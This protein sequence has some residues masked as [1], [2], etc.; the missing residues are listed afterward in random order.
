MGVYRRYVVFVFFLIF[1]NV[2]S[3]Y[4]TT[5][6][7][8][9]NFNDGVIDTSFWNY[10]YSSDG[11]VVEQ[12]GILKMQTSL[13]AASA[14][15]YTNDDYDIYNLSVS[16]LFTDIVNGSV[17]FYVY[18]EDATVSASNDTVISQTAKIVFESSASLGQFRL[19]YVD[20]DGVRHYWNQA[21]GVWQTSSSGVA[22]LGNH[23]YTL[24]VNRTNLNYHFKLLDGASVVMESD[25]LSII[26]VHDYGYG[27]R[28]IFGDMSVTSGRQTVKIDNL[29]LNWIVFDGGRLDTVY[30]RAIMFER[31]NDIAPNRS[32]QQQIGVITNI[33]PDLVFR[34][35]FAWNTMPVN[36]SDFPGIT[37]VCESRKYS[38]SYFNETMSA[39]KSVNGSIAFMTGF[40]PQR[41]SRDSFIDVDK[42]VMYNYPDTYAMSADL[43]KFG[44]YY[45]SKGVLID[46]D[47][48]Q[49]KLGKYSGWISKDFECYTKI[50][51]TVYNNYDP[52]GYNSYFPDITNQDY[53]NALFAQIKEM[54]DIGSEVIFLDMNWKEA[55]AYVKGSDVDD[56]SV[57]MVLRYE[58]NLG[59]DIHAYAASQGKEVAVGT[60]IGNY[61][62]KWPDYERVPALDFVAGRMKASEIL[63]G[64][65]DARWDNFISWRD[66]FF[67]DIPMYLFIDWGG[68]KDYPMIAFAQKKTSQGQKDFINTSRDFV[69]QYDNVIFVYPVHG[70]QIGNEAGYRKKSYGLYN[71]YDSQAPE[72]DTYGLICSILQGPSCGTV[73]QLGDFDPS[74]YVL[75]QDYEP[76]W[77]AQVWLHNET[78]SNTV[79]A[80]SEG[81]WEGE[82]TA[83][84]SYDY[85]VVKSGYQSITGSINFSVP[86]SGKPPVLFQLFTTF[87]PSGYVNDSAGNPLENAKVS[88]SNGTYSTYDFTDSSGYWNVNIYADGEYDYNVSREGYNKI[89]GSNYF[90][91]GGINYNWTLS[92][93]GGSLNGTVYEWT[94]GTAPSHISFD[95]E[96]YNKVSN[97]VNDS[98]G[99]YDVAQGG[100]LTWFEGYIWKI[101]DVDADERYVHV[102]LL[103]DGYEFG[104]GIYREGDTV[105]FSVYQDFDQVVYLTLTIKKVF[106]G[107]EVRFV[108]V[109]PGQKLHVKST[110]EKIITG[111]AAGVSQILDYMFGA[112]DTNRRLLAYM[113]PDLQADLVAHPVTGTNPC[114]GEYTSF[115]TEDTYYKAV[116]AFNESGTY[117]IVDASFKA[118]V[119]G[120]IRS[121]EYG[122]TD[123]DVDMFTES[124]YQKISG[125]S[126]CNIYPTASRNFSDLDGNGNKKIKIWVRIKGGDKP[127]LLYNQYASAACVNCNLK[128]LP[129]A[130]VYYNATRGYSAV[131]DNL[132]NYN[133]EMPFGS[134]LLVKYYKDGYQSKNN[135]FNFALGNRS[136]TYNVVLNKSDTNQTLLAHEIW[137]LPNVITQGQ[138]GTVYYRTLSSYWEYEV[139]IEKFGSDKALDT[140]SIYPVKEDSIS[141]NPYPAGYY[142]ASLYGSNLGFFWDRIVWANFTVRSD[143][144]AVNWQS[145]E[146][147]MNDVMKLD[148]DIPIGVSNQNVSVYYPNSSIMYTGDHSV[149]GEIQTLSWDTS[150]LTLPSGSY[151]A[152]ITNNDSQSITMLYPMNNTNFSLTAPSSVSWGETISIK[153]LSPKQSEFHIYGSDGFDAIRSFIVHGTG[154]YS[155]N[156]SVLPNKD[157]NIKIN[158]IRDRVIVAQANVS[159]RKSVVSGSGGGSAVGD[160]FL[161]FMGYPAFWGLIFWLIGVV[162]VSQ[163]GRP[164]EDRSKL[165]EIVAVVGAAFEAVIGLWEPY[166]WWVI[167]IIVIVLGSKFYASRKAQEGG[168]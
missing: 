31:L 160:N 11:S 6:S 163:G 61:P 142:V 143:K 21:L 99:L 32:I 41:M 129:G 70:G 133:I 158:L 25:D 36:C 78:W 62:G 81:Y 91:V 69:N 42:G 149:T 104:S 168:G 145:N 14:F 128:R 141:M 152:K 8:S 60:W 161:T 108:E 76:L 68:G 90:T 121:I 165:T 3:A 116:L 87:D 89:T 122:F 144:A 117:G 114:G 30:R 134:N 58:N 103:R 155:F 159:V 39:I 120:G 5:Y 35:S 157:Q 92:P 127:L 23:A 48:T 49:C 26:E 52:T 19:S 34:A 101:Q 50:N 156:T 95:L 112:A 132:G 93:K 45:D 154:S 9:D 115:G 153:Y 110:F 136:Q 148:I 17:G 72:F 102:I 51:D 54:I 77:G 125:I 83:A 119:S 98:E 16:I 146:Y 130:T 80:D 126:S 73:Q 53:Y 113:G 140:Y 24:L 107:R 15:A 1:L 64:Y 44:E 74:G 100:T 164:G 56:I 18:D 96:E 28:F 105:E 109:K 66:E 147:Y 124:G 86:G 7:H 40:A 88:I 27:D 94:R 59:G 47:L 139:R 167:S 82:V 4:A 55:I 85:I 12:S 37:S 46:H 29:N 13:V 131:T 79:Y 150:V 118:A 71:I 137:V 97:N 43:S 65:D 84:G 162:G 22:G 123:D 20:Y 151:L 166:T 63:N 57:R 106:T 67:G 138:S 75:D 10:Q 33:S 111:F 38:F 2:D 135:T